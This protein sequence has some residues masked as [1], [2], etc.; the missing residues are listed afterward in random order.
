MFTLQRMIFGLLVA[1]LGLPI[2][3]CVTIGLASL[4][5][6]MSDLAGA[7]VLY[8]VCLVLAVGWVTCLVGL[9]I[10][11]AIKSLDHRE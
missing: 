6:A 7:A 9:L 8:R 5:S 3:I 1:A 4:L 10:A 11:L 2:V